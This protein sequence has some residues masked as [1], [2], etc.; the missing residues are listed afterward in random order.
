MV[1]EA[2]EHQS[3]TRSDAPL[4]VEPAYIPPLE[5]LRCPVMRLP[6]RRVAQ[7]LQAEGGP[8]YV[9]SPD[10]I[11]IF[12]SGSIEDDAARQRSHYDKI[13]AAYEAN[14]SYPHTKAY[15]AYLNDALSDAV[16]ETPLGTMAEI[17]CGLGEA[18]KLFA[19]RYARAVGIDISP[20]MLQRAVRQNGLSS[21]TFAQGD[22]TRLPLADNA[23]DTVVML[24]G[25]HHIN[26]RVALFDEVARVLKPGG[27]FIF[28]EPVSDFA[29]WRWVRAIIYR[30]SPMLDHQTERPLMWS[31]TSPLLQNAGLQINHW[32]THGFI[33]FCVFMNS[34]VL[35][36]NRLF[37]FIP[38]IAGITSAVAQFDEWILKRPRL[39]RA[40]L[41]VVGIAARGALP[42]KP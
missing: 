18:A 16:G 6:L 40:G 14:L 3:G 10:G 38:G 20:A 15:L 41:Q 11:P 29:L 32:S 33:G 25:I 12:A 9:V 21:V 39:S 34:D 17:C 22:A 2:P 42:K 28:R 4:P 8:I 37:R 26:D 1:S 35:F 7:G 13:A 31:E 24:G 23:F 36:F 19:G 30:A 5:L 27:R